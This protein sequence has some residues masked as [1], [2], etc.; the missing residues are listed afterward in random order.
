[1]G[2]G[3]TMNAS[4]RSVASRAA[5][6]LLGLAALVQPATVR[7][8]PP[9]YAGGPGTASPT[10]TVLRTAPGDSAAPRAIVTVTFDRPVADALDGGAPAPGL[11]T[12]TPAVAGRL[13]WRDPV[14]LAFVPDTPFEPGRRYAA[15]V[16]AGI[17]AVDGTRLARQHAF[18]FRVPAG[19]LL[20]AHASGPYPSASQLPSTPVVQLVYAPAPPPDSLARVARLARLELAPS[21]PGGAAR[22]ALRATG[23]RPLRHD[24]PWEL[25]RARWPAAP[26]RDSLQVVELVPVRPLPLDCRFAVVAP[27]ALDEPAREALS[28]PMY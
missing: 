9:T 18:T 19:R 17:T 1:M 7:A 6:A 26:G 8:Q 2:A 23:R 14:T 10:L 27:L 4:R 28:S 15:T 22:V 12:I 25:Q 13:R 24:D 3:A 20:A 11:L 16:A 21:C 5:A